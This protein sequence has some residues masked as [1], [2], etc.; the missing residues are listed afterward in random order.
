MAEPVA[1][2]HLRRLNSTAR[3]LHTHYA[4]GEPRALAYEAMVEEILAPVR[5]GLRV[6]AAF[7]GHPGIFGTPAH[8]SVRRARA[9]GHD[10]RMLP[11]VSAEDCLFADLGVDPGLHGCA[12]YEA[13][14]FLDEGRDVDSRAV[15]VLWQVTVLGRSDYTS[16]PD[17][18][19][20][21]KLVERLRE[22]YPAEHEAIVYAASPYPIGGPAIARVA[23]SEL[24]T[25][26]LP[27]LATLVVPP[28]SVQ[29]P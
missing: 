6:C 1:A 16:E 20:L 11:G 29:R 22:T 7:Y 19:L 9:E 8:E 28:L 12:S 27:R 4:E 25:S 24:A 13:T 3:S 10:A 5:E 14:T 17:V 18:T 15:L 2:E 26:D 21:P 23:L